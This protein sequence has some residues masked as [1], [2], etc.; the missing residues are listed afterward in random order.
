M[1]TPASH[2]ATAARRDATRRH[3][4]GFSLVELLVAMAVTLVIMAVATTLLARTL[5]LR[6]REDNRSDAIADI[7]RGLNIM[8][9]EIASSGAGLPSG[10]RYT[11][12]GGASAPVPANGLL[13]AFSNAG[14]LTLVSNLNLPDGDADVADANE[15]VSFTTHLDAAANRSFLV[16]TDLNSSSNTQVLA[17]RLDG[18][19]FQYVNY[20]AATNAFSVGAA[21]ANTVAVRMVVLVNLP[22]V[23]APS[24]PGYQPPFT[25]RLTSEVALRNARLNVY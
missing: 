23:G 18:V 5:A 13:P 7:Q 10:L 6:V 3:E 11:P 15:A 2:D 17:N 9:R 21:S 20:D 4:A 24:S 14:T 25:T 1:N 12:P 8:S 22:A 16:R 19:Q